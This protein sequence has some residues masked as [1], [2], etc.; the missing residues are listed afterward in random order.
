[1]ENFQRQAAARGGRLVFEVDERLPETVIGD[2][3]RIMQILFNLAGN[4]LKF[5][6]GGEVR[7][8]I[9]QVGAG[10]TPDT[11]RTLFVVSDTGPGIPD[12]K[13]AHVFQA[14]TQADGSLSRRYGGAGLGLG[15]V[16]RLV[17]LMG[18]NLSVASTADEGT[19]VHVCLELGVAREMPR[20][21]SC[22]AGLRTRRG[23]GQHILVAEDNTVNRIVA[24][25]LLARL[26]YQA[27]AVGDGSAVLPALRSR[28]YD[29]VLMDVQ[30]PGLDG[31][32]ATRQV[33]SD[34]SGEFDAAIPIIALTAH[35][36]K[37]DRERFIEAGMDDY[38]SKPLDIAVLSEVITRHLHA[39]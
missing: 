38:V 36:M 34:T 6:E 8:E 29:L 23:Q 39:S 35:A 5:S 31:I 17:Q 27:E 1:M 2:R 11:V 7:V 12:D 18:G 28:R 20:T 33:R 19:S 32:S 25:K 15:I 4:A 10:R 30:M 22:R 3:S 9:A 13:V 37:G 21:P 26:G 24:V 16:R 14:F